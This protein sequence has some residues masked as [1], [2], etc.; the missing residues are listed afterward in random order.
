MIDL[1]QLYEN[2]VYSSIAHAIFVLKAPFFSAE[3]SW[4]G[5][6]Y[7]FNNFEGTR[8]TISFDL[9]AGVMAGAARD[10]TSARRNRYP[11]FKATE[12]FKN[13]TDN[14]KRLAEKET[15]EYLYDEVNGSTQP[16]ATIAFW[17]T[18][19]EIGIDDDIKG[20]RNNGGEY[21]FTISVT[22]DKLREHWREQ[23]ELSE[24]ELSAV[25]LI[26]E[27]FNSHKKITLDDVP[28]IKQKCVEAPSKKRGLFKKPQE[29]L[30]N[31]YE[32]CL[33]SLGELGIIIE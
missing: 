14:V 20:F 5:M 6:N 21:L 31:G 28:V 10:D 19:G 4:D 32:E 26:F 27:R 8:G 29:E 12:L 23:Y 15:L 18:G 17:S 24:A 1:L 11:E 7:C 13:A 3:Q 25:D 30:P 9:T 33:T 22:Y 16:T 2:C